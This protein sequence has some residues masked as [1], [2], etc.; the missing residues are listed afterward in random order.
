MSPQEEIVSPNICSFEF[1]SYLNHTAY[2]DHII[3][4]PPNPPRSFPPPLHIQLHIFF[5][6]KE[7]RKSKQI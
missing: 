4:P 7:K 2:F 5:S 6:Q 1:I 3:F